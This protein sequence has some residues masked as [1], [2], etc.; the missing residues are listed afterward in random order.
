M[1]RFLA[2]ILGFGFIVSVNSDILNHSV[3]MSDPCE[4][5]KSTPGLKLMVW[6]LRARMKLPNVYAYCLKVYLPNQ[7]WLFQ[8]C[9]IVFVSAAILESKYHQFFV[10]SI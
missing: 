5:W 10:N 8:M 4:N 3:A 2:I 1:C 7:N 9:V 6:E